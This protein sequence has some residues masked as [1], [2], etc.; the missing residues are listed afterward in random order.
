MASTSSSKKKRGVEEDLIQRYGM[1]PLDFLMRTMVE[2]QHDMAM[3]MD[4]AKAAAPYAHARL[5]QVEVI[6][7]ADRRVVPLHWRWR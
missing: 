3:R 5:K 7:D 2:P 1:T 4:A 6:N